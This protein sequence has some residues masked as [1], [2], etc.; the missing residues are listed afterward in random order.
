MFKNLILLGL[1]AFTL[2]KCELNLND[3]SSDSRLFVVN[4]DEEAQHKLT[5]LKIRVNQYDLAK[6]AGAI[7]ENLL[8]KEGVKDMA[9]DFKLNKT[10]SYAATLP[11]G[12]ISRGYILNAELPKELFQFIHNQQVYKV[13]AIQITDEAME[14]SVTFEINPQ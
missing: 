1:I 5:S 11:D 13:K 3:Q 10:F 6:A 2:G 8:Q 9:E 12:S 4:D 14:T 7:G